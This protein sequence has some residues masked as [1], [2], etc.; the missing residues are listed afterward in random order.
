MRVVYIAD[1]G[2]EFDDEYEC[3]DYEWKLKRPHLSHLTD[4]KFYD[5]DDNE[6]T[7]IFSEEAYSI[8]EL[9]VVLDEIALK[10]LQEFADYT[11]FCCYEDITECG[12]WI[13]N[14]DEGTFVK[15]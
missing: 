3:I 7:D 5:K 4:I 9:V 15:K 2:K 12:E 10:E 14:Y 11:G 13:F 1:D 6:L 8:T